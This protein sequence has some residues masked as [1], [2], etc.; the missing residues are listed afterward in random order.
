MPDKNKQTEPRHDK[1]KSAEQFAQQEEDKGGKAADDVE[2]QN[3]R[4]NPPKQKS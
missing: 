3:R 2:L 1:T 4:T